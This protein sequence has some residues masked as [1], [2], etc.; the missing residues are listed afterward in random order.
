MRLPQPRLLITL[1]LALFSILF[2]VPPLMA[3]DA[4]PPPADMIIVNA[5]I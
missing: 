3:S 2:S 5:R 1:L 4:P